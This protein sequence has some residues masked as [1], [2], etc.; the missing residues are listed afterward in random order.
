MSNYISSLEELLDPMTP[1][2]F[3]AEYLHKKPLHVRGRPE[4][5]ASTLTWA[6]LNRMLEMDVWTQQTL[7]L[8]LDTNSVPPAA[9]CVKAANRDHQA[10][11][12]PDPD[13]I[14]ALIGRGATLGLNEIETLA[15]G[16]L[17]LVNTIRRE[18]GAKSSV[19]LYYSQKEHKGFDAHSD[20]HDVSPS[21]SSAPSV[22]TFTRAS[23]TDR[24][25][26]RCSRMCRR[27]NTTAA[28]GKSPRFSR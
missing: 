1:E 19:N 16:I 20:R 10:I 11:M 12:R 3:C 27:W 7:L 6:E 13:K 8:N 18:L 23:S 24:S 17:A 15:P 5:F 2:T 4:K 25:N 9:Y 28:R 21:R 14:Q 22:G 26:T